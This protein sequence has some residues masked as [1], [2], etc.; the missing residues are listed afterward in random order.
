[1]IFIPERGHIVSISWDKTI[2]V[3]RA[4]RKRSFFK[5]NEKNNQ[6]KMFDNWVWDQMKLAM[7]TKNGLDFAYSFDRLSLAT[8][9]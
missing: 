2:K 5:R 7:K 6:E 8:K 4:Y 9:N 1:M 3:W